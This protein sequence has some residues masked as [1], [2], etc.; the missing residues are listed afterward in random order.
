M[1]WD[2]MLGKAKGGKRCGGLVRR[3][4][5]PGTVILLETFGFV[6]VK[7]KVCQ[8]E[9]MLCVFSSSLCSVVILV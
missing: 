3:H 1:T 5:F 7:L 9:A 4:I 6:L 2:V 8:I